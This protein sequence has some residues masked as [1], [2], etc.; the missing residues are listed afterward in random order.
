[1]GMVFEAW[2]HE[3]EMRVALKTLSVMSPNALFLFKEEFRSL[4]GILHENLV[5]LY[6][7]NEHENQYFLSMEFVEGVEFLTAVHTT[8]PSVAESY[9]GAL[10]NSDATETMPGEELAITPAGPARVADPGD[11][12]KVR[13][14]M[15]QVA[16]GLTALHAA[17]KLHR[18]MKPSNVLVEPGGRA[19]IL[20]FGL[21]GAPG[22]EE[23]GLEAQPSLVGTLNYMPP[24]QALGTAW[25]T[26]ASDWFA[27]GV[28]MYQALTGRVPFPPL[29]T[30]G[31]TMAARATHRPREPRELNPAVPPDLS[32]LCAALLEP[33]P[34]RRPSG[35]EVLARLGHRPPRAVTARAEMASGRLFVGRE[36][37]MAALRDTEGAVTEGAP[38]AAL[39]HGPSGMG[40]S[41]L[42]ERF[43]DEFRKRREGLVFQSRCYEQESVPFKALDG[44]IDRLSRYLRKLPQEEAEALMPQDAAALAK[45]FP[46]LDRIEAFAAEHGARIPADPVEL[47]RRA[48]AALREI[49]ARISRGVPLA[50]AID[51]YQ[52]SDLDS[53]ALIAELL[54]PPQAPQVLL[55]C[56]FRSEY[57]Q[58][59]PGLKALLELLDEREIVA[60]TVEVGPLS[61]EAATRLAEMLLRARGDVRAARRAAEVARESGGLPFF[62]GEVARGEA[63][64]EGGGATLESMILRR[65]EALP[66]DA[67]RLLRVVA[68]AG[69][70]VVQVDAFAAA[71]LKSRSP[72]TLNLLT[73]AGL[74]R[75]SGPR[76]LDEVEPFHDRIRETITAGLRGE[77]K[78]ELH[79]RLADVMEHSAHADPET[80]AVHLEA[81]GRASRAGESYLRAARQSAKAMAFD[82]AARLFE[83]CLALSTLSNAERLEMMLEHAEALTNAGRCVQAG[84]RLLEASSMARSDLALELKGKAAY[85]LLVGGE[86][87]DG[88][89]VLEEGFKALRIP[90]V[91][92]SHAMALSILTK[93]IRFR[94]RG[95]R[96]KT[97]PESEV[98]RDALARIDFLYY[99]A[100]GVG[101]SGMFRAFEL[102][103]RGMMLAVEAGEPYRLARALTT[104]A[105]AICS[106]GLKEKE[107]ALREFEI[108][109]GLIPPARMSA[110]FEA[111]YAAL[112]AQADYLLSDLPKS[113][114]NAIRA[115][116][117]ILEERPGAQHLLANAR[118][119]RLWCLF[120]LG[121]IAELREQAPMMLKEA[122][123][124]GDL[125]GATNVG[126]MPLP[127]SLLAAGKPREAERQTAERLARWSKM[128]STLQDAMA[129]QALMAVDAYQGDHRKVLWRCAKYFGV[130]EA[131]YFFRHATLALYFWDCQARALLAL[132]AEGDGARERIRQA[133]RLAGRIGRIALPQA[134]AFGESLRAEMHALR[135]E[136]KQA[137][138]KERQAAELLEGLGM[139]LYARMRRRRLGLW[140]GGE[141]GASMAREAEMW[142]KSERI[143]DPGRMSAAWV[144]PVPGEGGRI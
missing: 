116:R 133:E 27:A 15:S 39:V 13:A 21:V 95:T 132:A 82:R 36:K 87:D 11:P 25:L 51:D 124:R 67:R 65:V 44:I 59:S 83:R 38:A 111:N 97:K 144:N 49:L 5:A 64:T 48:A 88:L 47:K 71:G 43:L 2:D 92:S 98:S 45:M 134:P 35:D 57:Q 101:W 4:A 136:W 86:Y 93:E 32:A 24:E 53:S 23:F 17:G 6:E 130:F 70:G 80:L 16:A 74:L 62:I 14:I 76:E 61:A 84:R 33:D 118:L 137:V 50:L 85:N 54:A 89:R 104:H 78:A 37:E 41:T 81:C 28:M 138:E 1:M 102:L 108:A 77:E 94:W 135:G 105:G 30:I 9:R 129:Q 96:F 58:R 56:S 114:E 22:A 143:E 115:E 40:K 100:I 123:S 112:A 140:L 139:R 42:V 122:E 72:A 91:R 125:L 7:L 110:E 127:W 121:R 75:S 29:G 18:D 119:C 107:R 8:P 109:R 12:E 60:R 52:W 106:F 126:T 55:V 128:G 73:N 26:Q 10:L 31:E 69:R 34:E 99:A 117:I 46:V 20:D 142:M 66:E 68:V 113:L 3:R 19:V 90:T 103:M 131:A 141:A 79:A 120:K 63:E